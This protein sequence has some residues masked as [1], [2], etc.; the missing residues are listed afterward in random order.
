MRPRVAGS[1]LR[2]AASMSSRLARAREAMMGEFAEAPTSR[3][4]V[5][6][7]SEVAFGGDGEAG[8]E[9]VDAEACKLMRHAQL[10]RAV[11]GGSRA[12]ARRRGGWCRRSRR[13]ALASSPAGGWGKLSGT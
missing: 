6:M 11:H 13:E 4:M 2:A 5:R 8:F 12:T 10:F 3:A 9:D 1:M 7:D